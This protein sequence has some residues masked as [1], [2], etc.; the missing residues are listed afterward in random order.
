[1]RTRSWVHQ[2]AA[3]IRQALQ[4]AKLVVL[5]SESEGLP[6]SILEAM[7]A[8]KPVLVSDTGDLSQLI[9]HGKNGF[10]ITRRTPVALA[11]QIEQV[12]QR[13]DLRAIGQAAMRSAK[14]FDI[15]TVVRRYAS[16]Y[17]TLIG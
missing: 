3:T 14:A 2:G 13:R 4:R 8:G 5:P 10:L 9:R 6:L 12:T 16:L 7:A 15:R 11:A 17:R 1:M